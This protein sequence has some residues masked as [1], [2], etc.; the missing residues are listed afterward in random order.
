M[1]QHNV[2]AAPTA[3]CKLSPY[4]LYSNG[5]ASAVIGK[6][7]VLHHRLAY[8]TANGI[9]LDAIA[10]QVVMHTCDVRN[11]INPDHLVLGTQQD[12]L[13]DMV[14][15]GRQARG[16]A[17]GSSKLTESQV[18][19]IRKLYSGGILTQQEIALQYNVAQTLISFVVRGA[20]WKHVS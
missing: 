7:K 3:T 5:Y 18:L 17:N 9:S 13:S 8:C 2:S 16:S 20:G 6:K 14:S 11:C 1:Q 10:N 15:K 12:N 4:A 19:E